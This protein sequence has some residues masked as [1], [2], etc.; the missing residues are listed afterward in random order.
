MSKLF[1]DIL[2]CRL[3]E[4]CFQFTKTQHKL[5]PVVW[6]ALGCKLLV[7]GQA[8]GTRVHASGKPFDDPSR[9][10]LRDWLGV[11]RG[12]FYDT[13][14][15]EFLPMAF[16]FPGYDAKNVD[17]PP[18]KLCNDTSHGRVFKTLTHVELTVLL[19]GYAQGWYFG[20]KASLTDRLHSWRDFGADKVVLPHPFWRNN[21]FLKQ[22]R[23]VQDDILLYLK[24]QFDVI[25]KDCAN[26]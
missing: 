7:C 25:L 10:R 17:L 14:P 18:P 20:T 23:I 11:D 5:R 6:L 9:D 4:H 12:Q 22:N 8:S 2:E 15:F 24:R 1:E 16:W 3:C 13:D 26:G 21:S 19:C